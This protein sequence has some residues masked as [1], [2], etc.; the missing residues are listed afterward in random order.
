[1]AASESPEERRQV[2]AA[3]AAGVR[4]LAAKSGTTLT[5]AETRGIR[6]P[7]EVASQAD[8][9]LPASRAL[10]GAATVGLAAADPLER[11]AAEVQLLAGAAL[12]LIVAGQLAGAE[13]PETRGLAAA[14]ADLV[15]LQ[16]LVEAPEAYLVGAVA[17]RGIRGL[18]DAKDA[19]TDAV[20]T[21]LTTIKG[22]VLATGGHAVEGLLLMDAALLKEA[23]LVIGGE[24]A[25]KIGADFTQLARRAVEFVIA[26]NEKLI[27]LMGMDAIAE[28][29]RQLTTWLEQLRAGT[30]FPE[31]VEDLY[32]TAAIRAEVAGQLAGFEGMEAVLVMGREEVAGLAGR[33]AAKV[34]VADKIIS[35]L[36]L[37]KLVPPLL[38]PVGRLGVAAAYLGVIAYLVGSG[39][40]HVDSDRLKL[41]DRVEGV[42]GIAKRLLEAKV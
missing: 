33:F 12:D 28:A 13:A 1:M 39:Y 18:G 15:L 29:Q 8:E 36:A 23:L 14:P 17:G 32:Q 2:A 9:L 31:L 5:P 38:T 37:A 6:G 25:Q 42:R 4:A 3:Y 21:A 40:D 34:S 19:F 10:T 24:L 20:D 27:E 26:A 11:A 41:L 16:T 30:L 7:V 22:S 35:A